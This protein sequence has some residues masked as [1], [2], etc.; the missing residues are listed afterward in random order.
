MN[1]KLLSGIAIGLALSSVEGLA[2]DNLTR[3]LLIRGTNTVAANV[4]TLT[5][6][7]L[8]A[9]RTYTFPNYSGPI[10]VANAPIQPNAGVRTNAASEIETIT[11][12][13]GQILIGSSGLAP[14]AATLTGTTNQLIVTNGAGAITLSLPQDIHTGATP[15]FAGMTL[16]GNLNITAGGAT[17]LGTTSINASGAATTSIGN[18]TGGTVTISVNS[19]TTNLVLQGIANDNTT[20]TFLTLD[21]TNV[22]N[23]TLA[24]FL[25][26]NNGLTYNDGGDGAFRLGGDANTDA[27]FT[28]N[29]F[30][31]V[32]TFDLNITSNGGAHTA[33][34]IDGG[35]NT[36]IELA[37][38][39]TGTLRL[40]SSNGITLDA[41]SGA[42][43]QNINVL[44]TSPGG[45]LGLSSNGQLTI[46]SLANDIVV[47]T[48]TL[49][50]G[51]DIDANGAGGFVDI[52]A[53]GSVDI[54]T[55]LTSGTTTIGRS[56]STVSVLGGTNT[57]TGTTDINT[58]GNA[59][60]TIGSVTNTGGIILRADANIVIDV[61]DGV[62]PG[63]P[64]H[65]VLN[66]IVTENPITDL[67]WI[68][69][70]NQVRRS[71]FASSANEG[72]Q[73]QT[74]AYRLGV[75][76]STDADPWNNNSLAEN[77]YVNLNTSSL[78][79]TSNNSNT[80]IL[81]LTGNAV[82]P[83]VIIGTAATEFSVTSNQLNIATS[84]D[85]SDAGGNVVIADN[86][87]VTGTGTN[88]IGVAASTNT[89]L[90][91][92]NVTGATT[93]NGGTANFATTIGNATNGGDVGIIT[94]GTGAININAGNT[95]AASVN[96]GTSAFANTVTVGNNT[97]LNTTNLNS[98]VITAPNLPAGADGDNLVTINAGALRNTP[99]ATALATTAWLIGG[100]TLTGANATRLLGIATQAANEDNLAIQTDGT[101][102]LSFS[103]TSALI[104][105][106]ADVVPNADNSRDLGTD[107]LRWQDVYMNGTS[108]HIGP[109]GGQAGNTELTVGYAANAATFNVNAGAAELTIEPSRLVV[110]TGAGNDMEVLETGLQRGGQI[111]IFPGAGSI[112]NTN[113]GLTV[114]TT[115]TLNGSTNI[116]DDNADITTIRGAVNINTTNT[117]ATTTS[118]GSSAFANTIT[119]G[120]VTASNTT[121]LNSPVITAPNIPAGADGDNLLTINA[122]AVRN[123]SVATAL[124][125]SVW[126]VG[127]NTLV[128][129]GPFTVGTNSANDFALESGGTT[130]LTIANGSALG[131]ANMSIVPSA[132]NTHNL[133]SDAL[134]WNDVFVNGASVHIG[135]ALATELRLGYSAN[136]AR[137]F[138]DNSEEMTLTNTLATFNTSVVATGDITAQGGNLTVGTLPNA[139]VFTPTTMTVL[140][141]NTNFTVDLGTGQY[142][143][144]GGLSVSRGTVLGNG[145]LADFV[146][147]NTDTGEN[148]VIT[149]TGLS[150]TNTNIAINPNSGFRLTTNGGITSAENIT[151]TSGGLTVTAGG[152]TINGTLLANDN[153]TI[154]SDNADRLTVNSQILGGTPLVFQGATDNAFETS[155]AITEPTADQTITFPDATGTVA[156]IPAA[157]TGF[158]NYGTTAAQTNAIANGS[159]YLFD[160]EYSGVATGAALGGVIVSTAAGAANAAATGLS[161][162]ATATGA[163]VSLGISATAQGGSFN[164][165]LQS[166]ANTAT[167]GTNRGLSIT[168]NNGVTANQGI[169]INVQGAGAANTGI[170]IAVSGGA[171]NTA[172]N[173]ASGDVTMDDNVTVGSSNADLVTVNARALFN[174]GV[175]LSTVVSGATVAVDNSHHVII[176]TAAA[177]D[178]NLPAVPGAGRIIVVKN[179][180]GGAVN[181]NPDGAHNLEG[182]A[183]GV[184]TPIGAGTSTTL[185]FSGATWYQIGN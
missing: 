16:N 145:D 132:T 2:Q 47:S 141:A 14:Q 83:V 84:G 34:A 12:T 82:T 37:T 97:A 110:S 55:A 8:T 172:I 104:T 149:E 53:V 52:D 180:S 140:P 69:G 136:T 161:V 183:A 167:A 79:F 100:N 108:L 125:T 151:I 111:D 114:A 74:G 56:G 164:T 54:N 78:L 115:T 21:G 137:L 15:T 150:R 131:T 44:A 166:I 93:I 90:G 102:R 42:G 101:T 1:R 175:R 27:P 128:G 113:G 22:R 39:G 126:L 163:A 67:L 173:V 49:N 185:V 24:S 36:A 106:A 135:T 176:M 94:R 103:G 148:L 174:N 87:D 130:R 105:A 59:A 134:R 92:T 159:R 35:A 38:L 80:P 68:N 91:T 138:V 65:L 64:N 50:R 41:S 99:V 177:T 122:G 25:I 31:N 158:V 75:A 182:L 95:A 121:N 48:T 3:N 46:S 23:R 71:P 77:R 162:T 13:D 96:I 156:L 7:A 40:T 147:I 146:L 81:T 120:H 45:Q 88:N 139:L 143:I 109:T 178:V 112:I 155:F 171:S 181:I 127:G 124:G 32:N 153:V 5:V 61:V 144:T 179:A 142:G 133:G 66:N 70:S 51:I 169:D 107:A 123:T 170:A 129:A 117:A 58:T 168:V 154:G 98:P 33:L 18:T 152:A 73:F 184:G 43:A 4:G 62:S 85:I 6:T 160:V 30:V 72:I 86:L 157:A 165:A 26:A 57:I 28:E 63:T 76:A 119:I 11:M 9:P 118:I 29:R 17:V 10:L 20:T 116:G 89:V 60:T 19:G